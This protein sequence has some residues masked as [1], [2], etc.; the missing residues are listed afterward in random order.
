MLCCAVLSIANLLIRQVVQHVDGYHLILPLASPDSRIVTR[1]VAQYVAISQ[2]AQRVILVTYA[3]SSSCDISRFVM[4]HCKSN[5][6][7]QQV[8]MCI[9]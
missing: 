6:S 7:G 1:T 5:R 4:A 3:T 2:I 9:G 8:K